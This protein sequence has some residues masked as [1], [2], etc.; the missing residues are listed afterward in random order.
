MGSPTLAGP[1]NASGAQDRGASREDCILG[2]TARPPQGRMRCDLLF[3]SPGFDHIERAA[4]AGEAAP[5]SEQQQS[6]DTVGCVHPA[7]Q[8]VHV[9]PAV[10][11]A[12]GAHSVTQTEQGLPCIENFPSTVYLP[13]PC[14]RYCQIA[15]LSI[16]R[17]IIVTH[18]KTPKAPG[19]QHQ[20]PSLL[21][22][23]AFSPACG[24]QVHLGSRTRHAKGT[25]DDRC[26]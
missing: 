11:R 3:L 18:L 2:R 4:P 16:C 20:H 1:G 14:S 17:T 19:S 21:P 13:I 10:S 22:P 12:V 23:E 25:Q 5:G 6:G 7:Q 24:G 9:R 26:P 15:K 8:L